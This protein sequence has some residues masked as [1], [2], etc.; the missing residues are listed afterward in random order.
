MNPKLVKQFSITFNENVTINGEYKGNLDSKR[1]VV[2]VHGFGVKRD[3]RGLFTQIGEALNDKY[4]VVRFDLV[5]ILQSENATKVFPISTQAQM[6]K[7][8][9][10]YVKN[11][12][13]CRKIDIIA[14]SLG[15]LVTGWLSPNNIS[16]SILLASP[17]EP[18]YARMKAYFELR[19]DTEFNEEGTSRI[20][21][22][23]GS[24]TLVDQGFWRD[25][26]S[27]DPAM[28]YT[29]LAVKTDLYFVRAMQDQVITENNYDEIKAIVDLSYIELNGDHNFSNDDRSALINTIDKLLAS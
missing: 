17:V 21:R 20:K 10:V 3:S 23:D 14:H 28:I 27:I 15:C 19:A 12:L 2:F 7:Q 29:E 16:K 9:I 4:L 1:A 24:W 13:G 11:E 25:I 5:E 6:L 22:S 26:K 8:V 18:P